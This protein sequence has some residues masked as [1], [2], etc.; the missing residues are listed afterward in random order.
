MKQNK[1][2]AWQDPNTPEEILDYTQDVQTL[3]YLLWQHMR[4]GYIIMGER[5]LE[6]CHNML[7]CCLRES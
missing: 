1:I 3:K 6:R 5:C 4:T 7:Y 2:K